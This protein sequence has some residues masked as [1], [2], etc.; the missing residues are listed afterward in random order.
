MKFIFLVIV[1]LFPIFVCA[2]EGVKQII[3]EKKQ[4]LYKASGASERS[5][6]YYELALAYFRD[7]E[8]DRAFYHFLEALKHQTRS[9]PLE[10]DQD[11]REI[12]QKALSDYLTYSGG[13]P[14]HL[15]EELLQKYGET[16]LQHPNYL[17]L[18]FLIA[19]AY[20]NLGQYGDFFS[21]FY[22]GYPYLHDTFLAYKTQGI[23][24]LRLSHHSISS[25]ERTQ[26]QEEAFH[27]LTL[28][29]TR[30]PLDASVYKVLIF[31]AKDEKNTDLILSYLQK[32]VKNKVALPR[33]DICL[34]IKEAVALGEFALGQ[35]I[36]DQ[37]RSHYEYSRAITAAQEYLN[38]H[39]RG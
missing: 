2:E 4:A 38:Q 15:A 20:A 9:V 16:A 11:E 10:M 22:R 39:R 7:Q 13:D 19:T 14:I 27:N 36:I 8:I 17:H 12:Y 37:A 31:L 35:E 5:Q 26:F 18:N 34:Y 6:I 1:V 24:N 29:L 32:M 23:L 30:N 28:A 33:S 3:V 25:D 21:R